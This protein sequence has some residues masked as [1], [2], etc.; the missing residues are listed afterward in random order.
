MFFRRAEF[1]T[2]IDCT[3]IWVI[4]VSTVQRSPNNSSLKIGFCIC[5]TNPTVPTLHQH[6]SISCAMYRILWPAGRSTIHDNFE[7]QSPSC[8]MKCNPPNWKSFSAAGFREY[9]VFCRRMD[10]TTT[11]KAI[12]SRKISQFAFF[13]AV[14]TT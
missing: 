12:V 8:W 14:P 10:T 7:R 6:T 13:D 1:R 9:D 5:R 3:F 11:S 4:E 2:L